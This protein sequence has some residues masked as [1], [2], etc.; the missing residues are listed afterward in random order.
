MD[1]K[2]RQKNSDILTR[3]LKRISQG[4]DPGSLRKEASKLAASIGPTDLATAEQNLLKTGYSPRMVHQLSSAFMLLGLI[5]GHGDK[6]RSKL[7]PSHVLKMVLAEH[8]LIRCFIA[9]LQQLAQRINKLDKL[10]DVDIHFRRLSHVVEHLDGMEEHIQREEDVIFP[11]L[12]KHGWATLCAAA[13]TD[14]VYMRVA[15]SDLIDLISQF[16]KNKFPDFKQ[17]LISTTKH[18]CPL[19]TEHL[20]QE[21]GV[22]YPIALEVIDDSSVWEKMKDIC[23]EIGYCGVHL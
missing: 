2:E 18:L 12:K 22:L 11:Y 23:D 3:L 13:Q 20:L 8:D 14:H 1:Q 17:K 21:E 15:V 10:T 7:P 4:Q 6:I 9:D 16:D 19:V 5:D